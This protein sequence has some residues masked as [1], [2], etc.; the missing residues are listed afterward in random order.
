MGNLFELMIDQPLLRK[1]N[2]PGNPTI[3]IYI[4]DKSITNKLIDL[5]VV[6]N[7]MTKEIFTTLGLHGLI[8]TPTMLELADRSHVK[9]KGVLEDVLI[10]VDSWRYPTDFLIL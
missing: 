7:V 4:D 1:Y 8:N 6:I 3:N 5:G 10:T 2:N 9:P